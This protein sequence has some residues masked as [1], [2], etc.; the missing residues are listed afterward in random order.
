MKPYA[1]LICHNLRTVSFDTE[2]ELQDAI[3]ALRRKNRLY[4]P[5]KWNAAAATY[6]PQEVLEST[7]P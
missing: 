1:V 5:L 3:T 4:V 2:S 6:V 7:M